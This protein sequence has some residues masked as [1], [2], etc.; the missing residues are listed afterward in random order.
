VVGG[1]SI[2]VE[3]PSNPIHIP[4]VISIY[5]WRRKSGFSSEFWEICRF[6]QSTQL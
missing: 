5:H 1:E 4:F 6:R 2:I 3:F